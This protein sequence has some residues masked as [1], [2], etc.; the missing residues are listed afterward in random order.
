LIE[1]IKDAY[2]SAA[3]RFDGLVKDRKIT[4]DLLWLLLKPN[5]LVCSTC[6]GTRKP[7]CLR[8]DFGEEKTT[9]QGVKYFEL[10]CRYLDFDGQVF[11]EVIERL[12]IEKFRGARPIDSLD[13]FPLR[14][15]PAKENL[16][17]QLIS[18]G[19]KFVTM[20]GAHHRQYHGTAFFQ[21]PHELH[22]ITVDS[23]IV[24]DAALFRKCNPNYPRLQTVRQSA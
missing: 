17:K 14:Y 2:K 7:R 20:M 4:Y 21:C 22:R 8:Y 9:F 18:C 15:H 6:P 11:G 23:R 13:A 19:E 24:I 3:E 12:E 16:E 5:E 1:S 10:E